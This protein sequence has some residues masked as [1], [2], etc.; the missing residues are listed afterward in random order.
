M[1][2]F[3]LSAV[4]HIYGSFPLKINYTIFQ[5]LTTPKFE[6]IVKPK[7]KIRRKLSIKNSF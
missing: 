7:F 2:D 5:I 4:Y 1:T 6:G 3:A